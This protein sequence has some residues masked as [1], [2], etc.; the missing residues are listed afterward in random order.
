[1]GSTAG[2]LQD[3]DKRDTDAEKEVGECEN[4]NGKGDTFIP[5]EPSIGELHLDVNSG[6]L[7]RVARLK[8]QRDLIDKRNSF[9]LSTTLFLVRTTTFLLMS[10]ISCKAISEYLAR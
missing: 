5:P 1:M 4:S 8:A 7:G 10:S 2:G 9:Y 6:D 3:S